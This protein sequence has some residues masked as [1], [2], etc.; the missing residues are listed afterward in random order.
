MNEV[1]ST[2]ERVDATLTHFLYLMH[3]LAPFTAWLLAVV[4]VVIA[5]ATRDKVR[6]TYLESHYSW[7]ARTFWW[8]V[9]WMAVGLLVTGIL[10]V[11]IIGI[12]V[13]WLPWAI[14][15]LWYLY[16]VIR[17]WLQLN[18]RKPI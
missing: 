8:A 7:L 17:G 5:M 11:T 18:D 12:L 14:L 9:F 2:E 10:F 1:P 4:A 6:G 13:W 16:R 15:L 3:A